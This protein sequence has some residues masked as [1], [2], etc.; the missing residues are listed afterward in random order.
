[1]LKIV[2][3]HQVVDSIDT[4]LVGPYSQNQISA[5][6]LERIMLNNKPFNLE[7]ASQQINDPDNVYL[8]LTFDDGYRDNLI[9]LLPLLEKYSYQ[10]II[11]ITT[12]FIEGSLPYEI[13]LADIIN[14]LNL[15]EL[16][17]SKEVK[18]EDTEQK[19]N[20]Y[21]EIR[22]KL[23]RVS[24]K[25]RQR[26]IRRLEN[27]NNINLEINR[28]LML[29]WK[30]VKGLDDHELIT[31]GAH[32]HNHEFYRSIYPWRGYKDAKKSKEILENKLGH[33]IELFAYPYGAHNSVIELIMKW[34]GF[35]QCFTTKKG[36]ISKNNKFYSTS[37]PRVST[38][39][40]S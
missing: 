37:I 9:N 38:N 26:Y 13:K 2:Y 7:K 18:L 11:F 34:I 6:K 31:I 5:Q 20:A 28:N 8:L 29:N 1:M 21:S 25:N 15:I 16:P 30:E 12:S 27:L 10:A 36:L 4:N 33:K 24:S 3:G 19:A 39:S 40:F 14:H 17:Q 22:H 32:G 35:K 23:K